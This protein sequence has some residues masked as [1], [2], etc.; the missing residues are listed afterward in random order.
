MTTNEEH[1]THAP[2]LK[3][4]E[5]RPKTPL[6]VLISGGG[7]GGHVFPALAIAFAV[8]RRMP[9]AEVEFVGA[10]GRIE[11][12]K[13]PEHG[14][15]IHGLWI[16]GIQR[17][18]LWKNATLPFKILSS[19]NKV[20][21]I[22]KDFK[23]DVAIGVGGYAS[24]PLLRAAARKGIPTLIQEQNSF[25]GVTNKLLAKRAKKICVAYPGMEKFFDAGKLVLTGNPVRLFETLTHA[26][27]KEAYE[28]FGLS[29]EKQTILVTGG[30]GG[31]GTINRSLLK[32]LEKIGS[33]DAQMIWQTGK[34]YF[35]GIVEQTASSRL[36]NIRIMAFVD[37]MDYAYG[38]AD[39]VV[40]RAGAMSISELE[41]LQKP[42]ILVPSPNVAEDHQTKNARSLTEAHAAIMVRD[43]EAGEKLVDTMLGLLTDKPL[44]ETLARNISSFAKPDAAD[45]IVDEILGI[46]KSEKRA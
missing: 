20:G 43:V 1:I 24:G 42:V 46:I 4:Q 44:Q 21:R 37:R 35:H 8:K 19:L 10:L 13:V 12:E 39:V 29:A 27:K 22:L 5:S 30:S 17:R 23:P 34:H 40:S 31:A 3:T 38:I 6:R 11:M 28:Y 25:P 36:D 14:Y 41:L 15:K 18:Q 2:G 32:D 16:S 45:R 9:E 7:T 33:S 26:Q